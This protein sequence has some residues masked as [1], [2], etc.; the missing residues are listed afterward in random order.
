MFFKK[1]NETGRSMVEMLGV[2]AI[3]GVL[4]VGGV[5]G[6]SMAMRKYR[7]NDIVQAAAILVGN[8][9]SY[10]AGMGVPC[11]EL[12]DTG[13]GRNYGGVEVE[14]IAQII[15]DNEPA[16]VDI[17]IQKPTDTAEVEALCSVITKTASDDGDSETAKSAGYF[18]DH[19]G[20]APVSCP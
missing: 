15:D 11:L 12:S 19:C 2:L 14:M 13:L 1:K 5:Y 10:N 20:A 18:I 8:A 7:A 9:R 4:S 17:E 6:Y 16:T 3:I